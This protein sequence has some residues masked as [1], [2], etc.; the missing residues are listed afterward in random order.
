MNSMTIKK[1]RLLT[2]WLLCLFISVTAFAEIPTGYYN[3]IEGT[4]REALKTALFHAIQP[5]H[6]LKYGGSGVGYTWEGFS[7]TDVA[8]D[9]S[10][11]DRYSSNVRQFNGVKSV[12][13]MH[14]EH[15]FAKSW[16]GGITNNAYQDL[17]H[18]YPSDG[19]ANITKSN[20]P[21]GVVTE[22]GGFD[23]GVIKVG[24]STCSDPNTL[25]KVWEPSDATKGDFARTYMYMV[26]CYEDYSNLWTG[27]GLIMLNNETYPVFKTWV[28]DLLL[29]WNQEDPVDQIE[30]DRNEKVYAIQGNRNPFIDYPQLAEYIWGSKTSEAFYTTSSSTTPHLFVP[31]N[32]SAIDFGLQS[33]TTGATKTISI[34]GENLTANLSVSLS[35]SSFS[36]DK[37]SFTPQEITNG[38]QLTISCAP[39]EAGLKEASLTL[40]SGDL[41]TIVKL[42]ADFT[43]GIPTY[44]ATNIICTTYVQSFMANWLLLPSMTSVSLDVYTKDTNGN[45]TSLSGYPVNVSASTY[46]VTGVKENTTYY[47]SVSGNGLTSNEIQVDMPAKSAVFTTDKSNIVFYTAPHMASNSQLITVTAENLSSNTIT[48]SGDNPFEVSTDGAVW[49]NEITLSSSQLSYYTRINEANSEG[50]IEGEA[51]LSVQGQEDVI[52]N[53]SANVSYD[54]AFYEDVET[55]TKGSYTVKEVFCTSGPWSLDNVLINGTDYDKKNGAKSFRLKGGGSATTTATRPNGIKQISFYAGTYGGDAATGMTLSVDYSTD[56]GVTWKNAVSPISFT[57]GEWKKYTYNVN[58]SGE[59]CIRFSVAGDATK[60]I[61]LDDISY[62]IEPITTGIDSPMYNKASVYASGTQINVSTPLTT[63]MDIFSLQGEKIFSATLVEGN[64]AISTNLLPGYYIARINGLS[65]HKIIIH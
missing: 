45:K 16:W 1:L 39:Q 29:K 22:A 55:G 48:V 25:I 35:N 40:K 26:T 32:G 12:S 50:L 38:A 51:I 58:A 56:N 52:V 31:E 21:I 30:K 61:N 33:T 37:T 19:T 10:V 43:T 9:G 59:S 46:K 6:L 65:N 42:S 23:N 11:F 4:K 8:A 24:N 41:S 47:Y 62:S 2:T 60:R 14:I 63:S 28:K 20:N 54:R 7:Q 44:P 13:G 49:S 17:N 36:I 57:K 18:L 53:L 5:T 27:D 3:S 34:R 64:N 15:S